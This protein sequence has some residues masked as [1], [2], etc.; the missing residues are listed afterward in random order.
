MPAASTAAAVLLSTSLAASGPAVVLRIHDPAL[1]ESSG[2]AASAR[3]PDV[4]WTHADG[5]DVAQVR[6]VDRSGATVA[7]V[8]LAGIDPYDPEALAPGTD[9]RGRPLLFLGDIGDNRAVRPDVSVFRFRE[10]RTLGDRTVRATWYRFTYP[11]GPQDAEALLVEPGTGRLLI[12]TKSFGD[13][14]LYRAPARLVPESAGVNRLQRVGSV[15]PLVTD[16]A[17]LPDG[18]FVLR[19]YSD[20]H[21]Y[22]RPGHEVAGALLPRQ[23]QGESVAV[24]GGSLLV[25]SEGRNSAVY[26]VAV[27][28]GAPASRSPSASRGAGSGRDSA[29]SGGDSAA[30]TRDETWDG[31]RT[32]YRVARVVAIVVA[33]AGLLV[34]LRRRR[35]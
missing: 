30:S 6:A 19:T 12:A 26:R 10:P 25:G 4:V 8:T 23:P 17:F 2:L 24:D 1:V 27:P 35:R 34:V 33:L 3:H 31:W 32:A 14:G 20:L 21:V 22:D 18:R 15:P 29:A 28:G 11:D 16:G 7:V 13:A 9:S 5:G